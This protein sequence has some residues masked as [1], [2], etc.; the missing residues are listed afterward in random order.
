MLPGYAFTNARKRADRDLELVEAERAQRRRVGVVFVDDAVVVALERPA[1]DHDAL[2][3][4]RRAVGAARLG[5]TAAAR[6]RDARAGRAHGRVIGTRVRLRGD[7]IRAALEAAGAD[8]N[9]V[10]RLMSHALRDGWKADADVRRGGVAQST[11]GAGRVL[12]PAQVLVA[13]QRHALRVTRARELALQRASFARDANQ[14]GGSRFT[15]GGVRCHVAPER[16]VAVHRRVD[17]PS[18]LR[19]SCRPMCSRHRR[20]H[21]ASGCVGGS[22]IR[23]GTEKRVTPRQEARA[24]EARSQQRKRSVSCNA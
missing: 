16:R 23:I 9:V 4:A 6:R 14:D 18:R 11:I 17:A 21:A 24:N 15:V 5:E 20:H 19:R 8:A 1:G 7:E 13:N 22:V 10:A 12:F 3:A 2:A